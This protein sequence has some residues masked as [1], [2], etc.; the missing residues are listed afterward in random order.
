MALNFEVSAGLQR[1]YFTTFVVKMND[2]EE[3]ERNINLE[4]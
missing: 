4:M 2:K 3:V 1:L